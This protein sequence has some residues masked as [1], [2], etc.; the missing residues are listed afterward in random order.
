MGVCKAEVALIVAEGD[1]KGVETGRG[2]QAFEQVGSLFIMML[3]TGGLCL[4]I[5]RQRLDVV[6]GVPARIRSRRGLRE[7]TGRD[8]TS[9]N[10]N[11]RG[12]ATTAQA[13]TEQAEEQQAGASTQKRRHHGTPGF[14]QGR[15]GSTSPERRPGRVQ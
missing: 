15:H 10:R 6:N 12:G 13:E 7:G 1:F 4:M 2:G 8:R 11:W 5:K 9:H 14:R 3:L